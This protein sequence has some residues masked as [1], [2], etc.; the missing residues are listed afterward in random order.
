LYP[1]A[2]EERHIMK[3][4]KGRCEKPAAEETIPGAALA[5]NHHRNT[6]IKLLKLPT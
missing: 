3:G 4:E 1:Y 5:A 2:A 6:M